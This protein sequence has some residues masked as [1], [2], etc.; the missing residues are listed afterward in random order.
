M[1]PKRK[2][3]ITTPH[4][5]SVVKRVKNGEPASTLVPNGPRVAAKRG[6]KDETLLHMLCT[7]SR[8][9]ELKEMHFKKL[10]HSMIDWNDSDHIAKINSWRNQLYGRAGLKAKNVVMWDEE[11][12][13]WLELHY[14]LLIMESTHGGL[15]VTRA[16]EVLEDFNKFFRGKVFQDIDGDDVAPREERKHNAFVSK[17]NRTVMTSDLRSRLESILRGKSGDYFN[18]KITPENLAIYKQLLAA[19]PVNGYKANMDLVFTWE[20]GTVPPEN[21]PYI[22]TWQMALMG[23]LHKDPGSKVYDHSESVNVHGLMEDLEMLDLPEQGEL[24]QA[25]HSY[26]RL[27]D[28][29]AGAIGTTTTDIA[30][31]AKDDDDDNS[32]FIENSVFSVSEAVD[33]ASDSGLS[34]IN[35]SFI[36]E[37]LR[38]IARSVFVPAAK[39]STDKTSKKKITDSPRKEVTDADD[40]SKKQS[41]N[42]SKKETANGPRKATEFSGN[43][44]K[45][46][47]AT[48]GSEEEIGSDSESNASDAAAPSP[49]HHVWDAPSRTADDYEV[50]QILID[51]YAGKT[52]ASSYF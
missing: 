12:E 32:T 13:S 8:T 21:K 40:I 45:E 20:V 30:V 44:M 4:R 33:S 24:L 25:S 10:V 46:K 14:H 52:A 1:A 7:E 42:A 36:D 31:E 41:S 2:A 11:E 34:D 51:M 37:Q 48:N 6:V 16:K 9:G 5:T 27:T 50:A 47:E 43:D 49:G 39:K 3:S 22:D 29:N 15:M 23:M 38:P 35:D 17:M 18:P 19:A 26:E 28:I